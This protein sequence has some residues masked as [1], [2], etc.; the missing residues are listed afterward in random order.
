[1]GKMLK[2]DISSAIIELSS[3]DKVNFPGRIHIHT[4]KHIHAC[5]QMYANIH[6]WTQTDKHKRHP[7]KCTYREACADIHT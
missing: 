5:N 6:G 7:H 1:M 2:R 3:E 4:Q